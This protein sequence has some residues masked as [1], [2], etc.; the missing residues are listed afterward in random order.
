MLRAKQTVEWMRTKYPF[1]QNRSDDDLYEIAK[2]KWPGAEWEESPFI[3]SVSNTA[4]LPNKDITKTEASPQEFEKIDSYLNLTDAYAKEGIPWLGI[5]PEAMQEASNSNISGLLY[6][7]K[8]GK[9]KYNVDDYD[10]TIWE[11]IAGFFVGMLNPVDALAFVGTMGGGSKV[12]STVLSKSLSK[13][14][15]QKSVAGSF[16][17]K[18]ATNPGTYAMTQAVAGGAIGLGSY[19]AATGAISETAKQATEI[20]N[21]ELAKELYGPEVY[22]DGSENPNPYKEKT[23]YNIGDIFKHGVSHGAEGA[24]LGGVTAGT[25][26]FIGN[27]ALS[28]QRNAKGALTKNAAKLLNYPVQIGVEAG[29][30]T[31]IPYLLHGGPKNAEQFYDEFFTNIG[32]I[33]AMKLVRGPFQD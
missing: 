2:L 26:K 20:K 30:F 1:L 29:E 3:P 15:I 25:G 13:N 22:Q 27:R 11:N 14:F 8:H 24:L 31:T 10:K 21:P 5:S 4:V 19:S 6:Q 23:D 33:G 17:N 12:A 32:I 18:L 9:Q 16:K 7:I 28:I